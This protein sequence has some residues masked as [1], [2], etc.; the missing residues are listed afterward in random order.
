MNYLVNSRIFE[1]KKIP[2]WFFAALD[3]MSF[4]LITFLTTIM[5]SRIMSIES[6]S[7]FSIAFAI[8]L[9]GALLHQSL[10]IDPMLM[11]A[12]KTRRV[13]QSFLLVSLVVSFI[14]ASI[15]TVVLSLIFGGAPSIEFFIFSFVTLNLYFLRRALIVLDL[16]HVSAIVGF[17][18]LIFQALL[19]FIFGYVIERSS[20]SA[21]YFL[22]LPGVISI[23]LMLA[24]VGGGFV[25]SQRLFLLCFFRAMHH[26]RWIG[27]GSFLSWPITNIYYFILPV[28]IGLAAVSEFKILF[29]LMMPA[30]QLVT[31][32]CIFCLPKLSKLKSDPVDFKSFFVKVLIFSVVVSVG[33]FCVCS[34]VVLSFDEYIWKEAYDFSFVDVGLSSLFMISMNLVSVSLVLLKSKGMTKNIF[35]GN[36]MALIVSIIAANFLVYFYGV[37]GAF[38]SLSLS[39]LFLAVYFFKSSGFRL[40]HN[41]T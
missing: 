39:L 2:N 29:T 23:A 13:F 28:Y 21:Y 5:L 31:A 41:G 33:Y 26:G 12:K 6:F 4:S 37:S 30:T 1:L 18:A 7:E 25:F 34:F 14:C 40:S 11:A 20:S 27:M 16:L 36:F 19:L 8:F 32:L 22:A 15:C 38:L 3:Q 24:W 10:I 9:F 35:K 17:L